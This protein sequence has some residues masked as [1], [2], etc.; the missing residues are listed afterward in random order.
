LAASHIVPS[1]GTFCEAIALL[2][3]H[4]E[5][6]FG[7]RRLSSRHDVDG[8]PQGRVDEMLRAMG[9]RTF[10]IDDAADRYIPQKRWTAST[11]QRNLIGSYPQRMLELKEIGRQRTARGAL[12]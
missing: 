10:L 9:V 1:Y 3:A 5:T 6:Y 2:S 4:C 11:E 7:F 12:T 8:F